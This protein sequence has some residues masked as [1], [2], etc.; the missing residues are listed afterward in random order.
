M[1]IQAA[2]SISYCYD[3]TD[4]LILEPRPEADQPSPSARERGLAV[5]AGMVTGAAWRYTAIFD[6]AA[7]QGSR[8]MGT[9][10][11]LPL[12]PLLYHEAFAPASRRGAPG[13][14][15]T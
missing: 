14:F 13:A 11:G 1:V 5:S 7:I 8:L 10:P 6:D 3:L 4:T 12:L 9:L 15:P 2:T